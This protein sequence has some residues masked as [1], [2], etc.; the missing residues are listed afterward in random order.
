MRAPVNWNTLFVELGLVL[1]EKKIK[2][3]IHFLLSFLEKKL[4]FLWL[5]W[6]CWSKF[7]FILSSN[8]QLI[9]EE[10]IINKSRQKANVFLIKKFMLC[11]LIVRQIAWFLVGNWGNII[12]KVILFCPYSCEI[13]RAEKDSDNPSSMFWLKQAKQ[14]RFHIGLKTLSPDHATLQNNVKTSRGKQ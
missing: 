5:T 11:N 6:C 9:S 12:L 13:K 8:G 1:P 2:V 7:Y 10:K 4:I 3:H 14:N